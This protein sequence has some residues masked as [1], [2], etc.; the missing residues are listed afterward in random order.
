MRRT[1]VELLRAAGAR[2][3]ARTASAELIFSLGWRSDLWS[4]EPDQPGSAVGVVLAQDER[5]PSTIPLVALGGGVDAL[6]PGSAIVA[7][8]EWRAT[9]A[10]LLLR[11]L[12]GLHPTRVVVHGHDVGMAVTTDAPVLRPADPDEDRR[13]EVQAERLAW[14]RVRW[15]FQTARLDTAV[16]GMAA[17]MT[18]DFAR[19]HSAEEIRAQL[20]DAISGA[21]EEHHEWVEVERVSV[22]GHG[23]AQITAK[24]PPP[25]LSRARQALRVGELLVERL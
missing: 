19:P 6:P 14:S 5:L 15:S 11:P 4:D 25:R 17:T 22:D 13:L 1:L 18:I 9:H 24:G 8:P 23:G 7:I 10:A 3:E 16:V 20:R 2:L 21:G 12:L